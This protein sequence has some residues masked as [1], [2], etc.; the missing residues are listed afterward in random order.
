MALEVASRI[1]RDSGESVLVNPSRVPWQQPV[2]NF[3]FPNTQP[4]TSSCHKSFRFRELR[5]SS[6]FGSCAG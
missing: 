5:S 4:I 3:R 6:P 1:G 2:A